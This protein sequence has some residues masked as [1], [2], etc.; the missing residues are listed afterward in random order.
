MV[1]F[2]I[3]RYTLKLN[4]KSTHKSFSVSLEYNLG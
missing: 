4:L 2:D 3:Y 1:D